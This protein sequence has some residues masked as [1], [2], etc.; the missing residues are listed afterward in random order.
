MRRALSIVA[1]LSPGLRLLQGVNEL[2]A[3]LDYR[4][5]LDTDDQATVQNA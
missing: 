4:S 5:R 2:L 1:K 3:P